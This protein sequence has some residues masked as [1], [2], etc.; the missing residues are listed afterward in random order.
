M[1]LSAMPANFL[2]RAESACDRCAVPGSTLPLGRFLHLLAD[3]VHKDNM[4]VLAG[5]VGFRLMFAFLP[6]LISLLWLFRA[7]GA[8][9]LVEQLLDV[10]RTILPGAATQPIEEQV[11]QAP[12]D[13]AAGSLT[14]DVG[15]S[16]VVSIVAIAMA[17][18]ATMHGMNVIYGVEDRRSQVRRT[19]LSLLVSVATFAL[20]VVAVS[21]IVSGSNLADSV[22]DATSGRDVAFRW[23]W[24]IVAWAV[25]LVCVVSAFALTYYF[26]PDV[27]QKFRW[28]GT[29]SLAAVALWLIFTLLFSLYVNVLSNP[30]ETYGALAGVAIFL[31]YLYSTAFILFLGAEMN[32]V[33]ENWHPEGK[34]TGDHE[35]EPGTAQP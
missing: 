26:A 32:Q 30:T 4:T 29:G 19:V 34:D 27:E 16:L 23:T 33:I 9:G 11:Q 15:V 21:I 31:L 1:T 7:T 14:L 10:V 3:Q 17:F 2:R 8:D 13:Q 25:V 28:V 22:A 20:F 24:T 5:N 12:R 6:T 35:P 18:R